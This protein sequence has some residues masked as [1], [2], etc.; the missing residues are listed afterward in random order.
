MHPNR[1][2]S[3]ALTHFSRLKMQSYGVQIW[4]KQLPEADVSNKQRRWV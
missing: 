3:G 4:L 2:I 1:A